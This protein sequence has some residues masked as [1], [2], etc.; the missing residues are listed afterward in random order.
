[1]AYKSVGF[2]R[3]VQ[4]LEISSMP[5]SIIGSSFALQFTAPIRFIFALVTPNACSSRSAAQERPFF[6]AIAF[7]IARELSR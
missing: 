2:N 1:M 7:W 6:L 4:Y 5:D 3:R